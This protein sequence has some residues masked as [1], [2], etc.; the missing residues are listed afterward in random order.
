MAGQTPSPLEH[1][2][3]PDLASVSLTY[4]LQRFFECKTSVLE[5]LDL[6]SLGLSGQLPSQIGK[7]HLEHLYLFNNSI[8][9]TFTDFLGQLSF[10]R[11]LDL[12][13]NLVSGLIPFS[14]GQSTSM[15][16]LYL[17]DNQLN[18]TL[19]ESIG[20]LPLL[21]EL[22]VSNNQLGGSLPYSISQLSKMT[23]FNSLLQKQ[24]LPTDFSHG[25]NLV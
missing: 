6:S 4:L 5:S 20:R 18:G 1:S 19:P 17:S 8:S 7:V 16:V 3:R 15:E 14:I 23:H 22:D 21:K 10:L 12:G 25:K 11:T 13:K 9:G 24:L 2:S